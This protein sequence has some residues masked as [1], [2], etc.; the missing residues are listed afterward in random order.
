MGA[1]RKP[2]HHDFRYRRPP[3]LPREQQTLTAADYRR[4]SLLESLFFRC[5]LWRRVISAAIG[6]EDGLEWEH[7]YLSRLVEKASCSWFDNN[8]HE[9][10]TTGCSASASVVHTL[11]LPR[12]GSL[13]PGKAKF[14]DTEQQV[15]QSRNATVLRCDPAGRRE[16]S[17]PD[18]Q[19][20]ASQ[21]CRGRSMAKANN[22]DKLPGISEP[23]LSHAP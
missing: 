7:E 11:S 1:C 5:V 16:T 13:F 2:Q 17:L 15:T 20:S 3:L 22:H 19:Q 14:D 23:R 9:I 10:C 6:S 12:I 8:S 21:L 4:P 18:R